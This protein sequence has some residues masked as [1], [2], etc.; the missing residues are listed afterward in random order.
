MKCACLY[1]NPVMY[2]QVWE[3]VLME[4]MGALQLELWR[5]N[6]G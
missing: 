3:L 5:R 2:M 6:Q 1:L 4:G